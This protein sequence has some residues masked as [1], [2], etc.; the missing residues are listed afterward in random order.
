MLF[1]AVYKFTKGDWGIM[2]DSDKEEN[3]KAA[4]MGGPI[5]GLYEAGSYDI[6]IVMPKERNRLEV[7]LKHELGKDRIHEPVLYDHKGIRITK[8]GEH[9]WF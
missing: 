4:R 7:M 8:W 2:P 6:V 5:L 9:V 3:N 1:D